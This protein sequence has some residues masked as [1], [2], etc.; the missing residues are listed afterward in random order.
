MNPLLTMDTFDCSGIKFCSM[1][2]VNLGILQYLSGSVLELLVSW[3]FFGQGSLQTQ[4]IEATQR[5]KRWASSCS[6][7]HSQGFI[8][9]GH[10]YHGK[11][12]REYP[13]LTLKAY[14]GRVFLP[15][16]CL[17]L[18]TLYA[19]NSDLEVGL[20]Y[21]C[22]QRLSAW[23]DLLERCPRYLEA[24]Q[25]T[26]LRDHA[27]K[28]VFFYLKL[29]KLALHKGVLRY[30][31]TPKFH[32]YMC[33][34]V[35]DATGSLYNPRFFH[36]YIDEDLMGTMKSLAKRAHRNLLEYRVLTRWQLRLKVWDPRV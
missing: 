16:L 1:H 4:L 13:A 14:N 25:A 35:Q 21:V 31:V 7:A 23:F 12:G 19:G 24:W 20:A 10:L 22:C 36:C 26:K 29:A 17:C 5:F 28:F 18:S 30:A 11:Q 27:R 2:T 32:V 15:F 34:L 3:K 9:P 6:L 33:H 8:L